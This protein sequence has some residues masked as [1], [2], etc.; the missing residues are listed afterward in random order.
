MILSARSLNRVTLNPDEFF[1]FFNEALSCLTGVLEERLAPCF[2][3]ASG[4]YAMRLRYQTAAKVV[5]AEC[6]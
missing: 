5:P 2:M 3:Q 6:R 1:L 4:F